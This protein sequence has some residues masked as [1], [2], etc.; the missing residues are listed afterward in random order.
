ML[1][2]LI[3]STLPFSTQ[4]QSQHIYRLDFIYLSVNLRMDA[5][6]LT[7]LYRHAGQ[8]IV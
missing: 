1:V 2:K 8:G 6:L 3:Y 7:P 4:V 5:L